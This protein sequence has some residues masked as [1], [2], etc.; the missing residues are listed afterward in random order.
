MQ[1][2]CELWNR[3]CVPHGW[4]PADPGVAQT[5]ASI[6]LL[7]RASKD[8]AG[9]EELFWLAVADPY[10][11]DKIQPTILRVLA[12]TYREQILAERGKGNGT[13]KPI[14]TGT[15]QY[16]YGCGAKHREEVERNAREWEAEHGRT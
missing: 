7:T 10:R 9:S 3:I 15:Y 6:G 2:V 13:G 5:G 4:P 8:L 16:G 11:R 1:P 12:P 14:Q